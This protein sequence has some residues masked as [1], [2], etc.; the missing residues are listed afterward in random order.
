M[1]RIRTTAPARQFQLV[2][3]S[4]RQPPQGARFPAPA[5]GDMIRGPSTSTTFASTGLTPLNP[6][7]AKT[8]SGG[9]DGRILLNNYFPRR[10]ATIR[11]DQTNCRLSEKA[12][13]F[14]ILS[15][16]HDD[17]EEG[18]HRSGKIEREARR[19]NLCPPSGPGS[20]ATAY[21]FTWGLAGS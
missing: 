3:A 10:A 1:C 20:P 13:G 18:C 15:L 21:I 8:L 9:R 12:S 17:L 2:Q 16:R 6:L 11:V 19:I 4:I 5:R 14:S 7:G